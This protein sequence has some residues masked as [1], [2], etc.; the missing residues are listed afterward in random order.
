M[1][2]A[3]VDS[4]EIGVILVVVVELNDVAN[5]ATEGWSGEA[6]EDEDERPASRFFAKMEIH[7]AVQGDESCIRSLISQFQCATM[8]VRKGVAHHVDGIFRAAGHEAEK[9]EHSH[10]ESG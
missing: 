2:F 3:N 9:E 10:E 1:S 8:H 4:Q 6:A 5:L 7:G